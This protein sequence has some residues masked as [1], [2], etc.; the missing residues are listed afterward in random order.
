MP[1]IIKR[2]LFPFLFCCTFTLSAIAQTNLDPGDM[3][4][5]GCN[6]TAPFELAIVALRD[7]SSNTTIYISDYGFAASGGFVTSSVVSEGAITW[8]TTSNITK[9]TVFFITITSGATPVVTGLPGTVSVSGW[10]T[11]SA[12]IPVSAA[13]D[14]W[15]IYQG[16]SAVLPTR[17]VFGWTNYVATTGGSA[18]GWLT[19]GQMGSTL[20]AMSELPAT[21]T[22]GSTAVSLAWAT[23]SGGS[24][25][26]NNVYNSIQSG[27]KAQLLA[28]ICN[29]QNWLHDETVTYKLFTGSAGTNTK[30]GNPYFNGTNPIF[31][32]T[33]TPTTWNGSSWSNG[34]PDASTDAVIAGNTAPASFTCKSLTINSGNTLQTSGIAITV[35]G[36]IIN[37]GGGLSGGGSINIAGTCALSGNPIQFSG[38]INIGSGSL[39][40]NDL[41]TIDYLGGITGN[42][43]NISGQVSLL[44]VFV[45]QR[46]WRMLSNP[47]STPL[48]IATVAANNGINITTTVQPSGLTDVRTFNSSINNWSNVTGSSIAANTPYGLFYRGLATE[49]NGLNYTAGPSSLTYK[50]SGSV[51]GNS[52]SLTPVSTSNFMLAGNPY[53]GSLQTQALTGGVARPYYTYQVPEAGTTQGK[54][55][56]A[57]S[58]IAAGTNSSTSTTIPPMGVIAY[59]PANTN[60]YA[61]TPTHINTGGTWVPG[62][63]FRTTTLQQ[64]TLEV[65]QEG[66]LQDKLFIRLDAKATTKG[67]DHND[68]P[69]LYNE[70]VNGYTLTQ[71]GNRMAIDARNHFDSI[72]RLGFSAG[73]GTYTFK[74]DDNSLSDLYDVYLMDN[75]LHQQTALYKGTIVTISVT[76]DAASK[77]EARFSLLLRKK[78]SSPLS[79]FQIKVAGNL[80]SGGEIPLQITGAK[81]NIA[82][83]L[84]SIN[85]KVITR[86]NMNNGNNTLRI[87]IPAGIYLLTA[88][89]GHTMLTQ[90]IIK[91]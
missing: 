3:A 13:G 24:H 75:W 15:F 56:K 80:I 20:V 59:L 90:Q 27:S 55:T 65:L 87:T 9:G 66:L 7:I 43:D 41:L 85:G 38:I 11:A 21:L 86:T 64:L 39:T 76:A 4:I 44:Q 8:T 33:T 37:N 57:G 31:T 54:R 68:L 1:T 28:Q 61:I 5:I 79:A 88:N 6:R 35:Y 77:G 71:D 22:N 72:V 53:I 52:Y 23:T 91:L 40:T 42:Y 17:F 18:N 16:T 74:V 36:N 60:T 32:L 25:G 47:F 12:S 78:T 82:V 34:T 62:N 84:L 10:S 48:A 63:L 70:Q 29:Y 14:N 2:L 50:V 51:N 73:I 45:G 89:D 49:V 19:T 69:K 83:A 30:N 26:D 81:S 46:G 67:T 58:W